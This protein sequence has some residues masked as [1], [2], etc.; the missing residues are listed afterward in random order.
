MEPATLLK[1][2]KFIQLIQ[3]FISCEQHPEDVWFT[4]LATRIGITAPALSKILRITY[5]KSGPNLEHYLLTD[6]LDMTQQY[7]YADTIN[8]LLEHDRLLHGELTYLNPDK[9][10]CFMQT[11]HDVV[12]DPDP[13]FRLDYETYDNC[14][15]RMSV[16]TVSPS[17]GMGMDAKELE[18]RYYIDDDMDGRAAKPISQ[19]VIAKNI[20]K[21][22]IKTLIQTIL[23]LTY[24][25]SIFRSHDDKVLEHIAKLKRMINEYLRN[26]TITRAFVKKL[27]RDYYNMFIRTNERRDDDKE[28]FD[29][30]TPT[31]KKN[32]KIE[33]SILNALEKIIGEGG[34]KSRSKKRGRKSVHRRKKSMHKKRK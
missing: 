2:Q 18:Y 7:R 24:S 26:K 29:D 16:E 13:S 4:A 33:I 30:H 32:I 8:Q 25:S 28:W 31:H 12:H 6:N 10:M 14:V 22:E 21:K 34:G 1:Q 9:W 3:W 5:T 27:Y 20:A 11:L 23:R 15:S 19:K 17:R